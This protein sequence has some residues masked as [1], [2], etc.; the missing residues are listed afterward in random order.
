MSNNTDGFVE[1]GLE[2][3]LDE[4]QLKLVNAG[5][6]ELMIF[7]IDGKIGAAS[8]TCT[9]QGGPLE[10]GYLER[11]KLTCPWHG[12]SF[13]LRDG[14]SDMGTVEDIQVYEVKLDSGKVF[15][16]VEPRLPEDESD[17]DEIRMGTSEYLAQWARTDDDFETKFGRI[18][19]LAKGEK[20][21]IS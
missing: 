1:V 7:K 12:Y 9:H 16:S 15:V 8:N 6:Q 21:D 14:K 18:Q 11:W 3:E 20:S 17:E 19:R 2:S 4:G 13:D 5:D 10:D